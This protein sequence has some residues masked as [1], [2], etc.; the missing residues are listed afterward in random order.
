M[1]SKM[2]K[3]YFQ[4]QDENGLV[5][6]AT[7]HQST[8]HPHCVYV[9]LAYDFNRVNDGA[10]KLMIDE[11]KEQFDKPLFFLIDNRFEGLD[12]VLLNNG[13]QFIRKTEVIMIR[14]QK[15]VGLANDRK[16][17]AI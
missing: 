1:N 16:V 5:V 9:R 12:E 11:L 6:A 10:L 2:N 4:S 17:T 7:T 3:V 8:W 14:P 13:L 15:R